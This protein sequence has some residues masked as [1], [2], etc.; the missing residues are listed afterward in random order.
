MSNE[1]FEATLDETRGED[2][3]GRGRV[4]RLGFSEQASTR[5]YP[6]DPGPVLGLDD[7]EPSPA[8]SDQSDPEAAFAADTDDGIGYPSDT[9]E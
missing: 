1:E 6:D 7:A 4:G 5:D 2:G 8:T 9:A 3:R